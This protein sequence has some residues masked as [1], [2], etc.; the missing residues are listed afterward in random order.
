[1]SCFAVGSRVLWRRLSGGVAS[2][3][4]FECAVHSEQGRD[5][6]E[7]LSDEDEDAVVDDPLGWEY[8]RHG[9][10]CCCHDREEECDDL[11]SVVTVHNE[12]IFCFLMQR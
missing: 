1:M 11:F 4:S 8:E 7:N 10:E 9:A 3:E 5:E 6:E 2:G 12:G